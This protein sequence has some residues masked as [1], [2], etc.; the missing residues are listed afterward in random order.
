MDA[1]ATI[2]I[3]INGVNASM[4]GDS[5]SDLTLLPRNYFESFC[6]KL[7]YR[8]RL[9]KAPKPIRATNKTLIDCL[10]YFEATLESNSN[11]IVERIFVQNQDMDD[12]PL[13]SRFALK[14]LGYIKISKEGDFLVKSVQFDLSEEE[15]K[16]AVTAAHKKHVKVFQGVGTYKHFEVDL[17][18][19]PNSEP[20][21]IR[22]IPCPVHLREQ[23]Q[24][25]LDYFVK[26]GILAPLPNGYPIKYCS[27][28]L[29]IPKPNKKEVRLVVNYRRLNEQ[30]SRTRHVP[31]VGL[32]DFCRVTRGFT[33]WFRLDLRHAFHQLKLSPRAQD[34]TIISTF[35][36][37]FKW[38]RLPQGIL[39]ASDV[40]DQVMETVLANCK[41]TIS[42]RDDILGGGKSRREC[43][44]EYLKVLV[45]L[46][47]AGLT[48]DDEKTLVGITELVFFGMK[49]SK[50]GMSPDPGKVKTIKNAKP[51]PDHDSLNSFVCMVAWNDT[52]I[53]RFAELVR[54][55]RDLANTVGSYLWTK[56]HDEAFQKVKDALCEDCLNNYF[57][58]DRETYLFTDA[59]KK[60]H[61]DKRLGG[62][63]AIL[64]QKTEAGNFVAIHFASRSIN[65]TEA[66]WSQCELEAR[67]LRFGIDRFRYYFSG[68]DVLYCVVDCKALLP[69][70][71]NNR[72]C[73]PRIDRMRLATQD[74][75]IKLL[76]IDGKKMPADF[77]SRNIDE[78]NQE[79]QDVD[80]MDIS[81]D[82]DAYL[83]KAVNFHQEDSEQD[84][85]KPIPVETIRQL[86]K[87]DSTLSFVKERIHRNDWMRHKNDQRIKKFMGVRDE[88]WVI[89]DLIMKG[90]HTVV[91]PEALHN[92]AIALVH[93]LAHTGQ[94]NT[95][96]LLLNRLWF[97]GYSTAVRAEVELCQI[98][99]HAVPDTRREPMGWIQA[100]T[101]AFSELSI[102]FKGPFHDSFYALVILDLYTKWPEVFFVTSTSFQAIKKHLETFLSQWGNPKMIKT[103]S[104]PPFNGGE[105]RNFLKSR[106]I[107]HTPI[108]PE[109][110]WA[111]E[112]ENL[113]R[114]I[115]KAYTIARQNGL[116]Y[117][118]FI[119]RML[120][121]KRATPSVATKVSPHFAATGRILDPG[122]IQ[123]HLPNDP[124]T[125][126][127][128]EQQREIQKNLI[129]SKQKN[130]QRFNNKRN[131]VHLEL[132]PGDMVLVRLGKMNA[133][134]EKDNYKVLE[135]KGNEITAENV[136]TG[137]ILRRHLSRFTLITERPHKETH[138][139]RKPEEEEEQRR[140]LPMP[141]GAPP[142]LPGVQPPAQQPPAP[143]P[144]GAP[145]MDP[146]A[147]NHRNDD[148]L[149]APGRG[150]GIGRNNDMPPQDGE[151]APPQTPR[152][153]PRLNEDPPRQYLAPS[154]ETPTNPRPYLTPNRPAQRQNQ[155]I[156]RQSPRLAE[157]RNQDDQ[158]QTPPTSPERLPPHQHQRR[159]NFNQ[160]T[161]TIEFDEQEAIAPRLTRQRT[162]QTGVPVPE[163]G[164]PRSAI[165]SSVRERHIAQQILNQ[166]RT[167]T[168][169]ALRR[170]Q[171]R[172]NDRH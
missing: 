9:K 58:E 169:E 162:E 135:V 37:C 154:Q 72:A 78:S 70:W 131:V 116:D 127:S 126:L 130:A 16:A 23:A 141:N 22:A 170:N 84:S 38:L 62:F 111:N 86:T 157:R 123:G 155:Q 166:H 55:L 159:V 74:I 41:N 50:D 15:F 5:G 92:Q 68:I 66:K 132:K 42:M 105:F 82:L 80:D 71:N 45:A 54:P 163:F 110:P 145:P 134:P 87:Q 12:L 120:M 160:R 69:L 161:H 150:Q 88:L 140:T 164:V 149:P 139:I 28:L 29:V 121:V 21:V 85:P 30:L 20:I 3:C 6:T 138:G 67:A 96:R 144:H 143:P 77:A 117:K 147:G 47:S 156:P 90:S 153:S 43:L 13:L 14:A 81:D 122:I 133:K 83:V 33:H 24:Q 106:G 94:T 18:V 171:R 25:R 102:D 112:V 59:S 118:E 19:K 172:Q 114:A 151:Q 152:K 97:P 142:P 167:D 98:C 4:T 115:G 79:D 89:D 51:P 1:D 75:P 34:L 39:M 63:A 99:K 35:A 165:E 148:R 100:P 40:F 61:L 128:R 17:Q 10:G 103:D 101:S 129:E 8:P 64:S 44:Q 107:R 93:R 11:Q 52:F 27:P 104:G 109:T 7:G 53:H 108:I 2:R 91:L 124:E 95:E 125:G 113:M 31:A 65:P 56:E 57:R 168:N 73:P 146:N 36:G 119:R 137:R 136:N 48:C 76:H 49:F 46:E 32:Q 60:S 158:F 26:L